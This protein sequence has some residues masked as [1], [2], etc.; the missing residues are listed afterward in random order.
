V[1]PQPEPGDSGQLHERAELSRGEPCQPADPCSCS[2][3]APGHPDACVQA[4]QLPQNPPPPSQHKARDACELDAELGDQDDK[5][6]L[7]FCATF[8]VLA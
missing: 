3:L 4:D 5:R 7:T 2:L 6:V 8:G 1:L